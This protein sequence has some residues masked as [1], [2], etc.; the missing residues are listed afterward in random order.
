MTDTLAMWNAMP[1]DDAA[2]SILP[3]C[4]SR[5][6]ATEMA[7]RRPLAD[8]AAILAAARKVW[9]GLSEADWQEAFDSHPRI[10]DSHA[11]PSAAAKSQQWSA[12]EQQEVTQSADA[13]RTALAEGNRAYEQRFGRIFIVCATGKR[14][15]EILQILRRRLQNKD[16]EELQQAADEQQQI[17]QIRLRKWLG[18]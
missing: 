6:W 9:Q 8:G 17:T 14:P 18:I 10:G 3:C 15:E 4:G 1:S 13:V 16:T 2:R 7:S 12:Q 11:A 5:A